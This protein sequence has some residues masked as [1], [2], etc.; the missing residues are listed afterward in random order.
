[1]ME[2]GSIYSM[3]IDNT[4]DPEEVGKELEWRWKTKT[5]KVSRKY[6]AIYWTI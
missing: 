3:N 1:M 4:N 2:K 6:P 5:P